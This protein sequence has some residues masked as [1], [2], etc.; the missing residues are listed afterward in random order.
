MDVLF[1]TQS[2]YTFMIELGYWDT[3]L[4]MKQKIEKYQRIPLLHN[5]PVIA[6]VSPPY[7]NGQVPQT[8]QSP[9][10][11]PSNSIG[12]LIYGE[13]LPLTTELVLKNKLFCPV[14]TDAIYVQDS[15][16]RNNNQ[17]PPSDA[18]KQIINGHQDSTVTI[19]QEVQTEE[20]PPLNSV[21]ESNSIQDSPKK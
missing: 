5:S 19:H 2:G 4:E 10:P 18:S 6:F 20:S 21:I 8:E 16:A 12:D 3:V 7:P 1:E 11:I 15:S 9:V 17:S 14:E 13:D